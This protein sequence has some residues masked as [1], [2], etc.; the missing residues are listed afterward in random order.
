MTSAP[1]NELKSF[2]SQL[3][4]HC[5]PG[6]QLIKSL[7]RLS[8][9]IKRYCLFLVNTEMILI[10]VHLLALILTAPAPKALWDLQEDRSERR[11]WL[12]EDQIVQ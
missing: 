1:S 9:L 2:P 11:S 3:T 8:V 10:H 12:E 5:K 4:I 7:L 6:Q